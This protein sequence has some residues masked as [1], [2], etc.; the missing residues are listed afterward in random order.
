MMHFYLTYFDY[1]KEDL[2]TLPAEFQKYHLQRGLD[3]YS[4]LDFIFSIL[5]LLNN[6][7]TYKTNIDLLDEINNIKNIREK[8][9]LGYT[10]KSLYKNEDV[11]LQ[12]MKD[13]DYLERL[14]YDT[15]K[16]AMKF[17]SYY[18]ITHS[19]FINLLNTKVCQ[20]SKELEKEATRLMKDVNTKE[21]V[22]FFDYLERLL[23]ISFNYDDIRKK[24]EEEYLDDSNKLG[25]F[26]QKMK[27]IP[28]KEIVIAKTD[29][30]GKGGEKD[31]D[32]KGDK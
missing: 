9:M 10:F 21:N 6:L 7:Q 31:K 19:D 8:K 14:F 15:G 28:E 24:Q 11:Y 4:Y 32:K 17:G 12:M 2:G 29:K 25:N 1:T 5:T 27:E 22:N 3:Y 20:K 13:F 23:K 18:E 26:I 16:K 30:A